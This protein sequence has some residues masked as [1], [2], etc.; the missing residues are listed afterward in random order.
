VVAFFDH[1]R[2]LI[3]QGSLASLRATSRRGESGGQPLDV[4]PLRLAGGS[5]ASVMLLVM[6]LAS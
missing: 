6:Y 2:A 5:A 1:A 3:D 4:R